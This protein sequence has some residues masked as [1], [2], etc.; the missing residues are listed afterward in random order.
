MSLT[1]TDTHRQHCDLGDRKS[2]HNRRVL[3]AADVGGTKTLLG[4]FNEAP[5]RPT[6]VEVGEFRMMANRV[7][8]LVVSFVLLIFPDVNYPAHVSPT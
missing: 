3:L 5:E 7:S 8:R 2:S 1:P 4:L 6:V